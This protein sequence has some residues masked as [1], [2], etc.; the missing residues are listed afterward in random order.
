MADE[1]TYSEGVGYNILPAPNTLIDNDI[2][3]ISRPTTPKIFV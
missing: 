3:I 1:P 2:R